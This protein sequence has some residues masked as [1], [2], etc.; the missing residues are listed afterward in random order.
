MTVVRW[1][2]PARRDDGSLAGRDA[3]AQAEDARRGGVGQQDGAHRLGADDEEGELAG[4]R[5]RLR[6]RR[7]AGSCRGCG[8]VGGQV[9]AKVNET[10][11]GKPASERRAFKLA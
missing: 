2:V 10:G 7:S 8:Q 5:H 3:G 6:E 1:A 11:S 4:S 9:R